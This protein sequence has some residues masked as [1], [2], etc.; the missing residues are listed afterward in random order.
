MTQVTTLTTRRHIALAAACLLAV[1]ACER[2]ERKVPAARET[3]DAASNRHLHTVTLPDL[4]RAEE[5]VRTQA[6]E[7]YNA[8]QEKIRTG[9]GDEDLARAY[10]SLGMFLHAAEYLD[11]ALP[12]YQNAEALAPEDVRWPYYLGHLYKSR[13]QTSDATAAFTRALTLQP[14]D[15]PTLIWLAR[16]RLDQGQPD[17]AAPLLETA[18]AHAPQSPAVMAGLGHVALAKQQYDTA[19]RMFEQ[20]LAVD[21]DALSLHAP[22]ANAYRAV[23]KIELA[24]AHMKQWRNRDLPVADPRRE[25]LDLQ[26]QSGLSYEL[27]GLKAMQ[28]QDWK[29]A[30]V[31][32]KEG[33]AVAPAGSVASRSLH[34]KLGTAYYMGGDARAAINEFRDVLRT[35]PR[36]Q[37]DES[38]AKASYS[39]GVIL[40]SGGRF[41]DGINRL[42]TA[43]RYQPDYGEAHMALADALRRV[44]R[45][46]ESTRHYTEVMRINPAAVEAPFGYAVA[47]VRLGRYAEARQALE[48]SLKRQQNHPMLTQALARVLA[49]AP[50]ARV[51]DGSRALAMAQDLAR[52]TPTTDV[53][54]TLAM[55]LAEAGDFTRAVEMQKEVMA[56]A[57]RA[58]FTASVNMMTRN[59]RLYEAH[60][61]CRTPWADDD[62]VNRPGPA[63]THE[64]AQ[65]ANA[66]AAP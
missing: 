27:R 8:L 24:E 7:Y 25:Q 55:A 56:A 32:F 6:G 60:Q 36:D 37:P 33:L 35:A 2:G 52:A 58:G 41:N 63:V 39:L 13:G 51:R 44:G 23:G 29:G 47:L 43:V 38:A 4:G 12:C 59:L 40:I 20:G 16:L 34:H 22:L 48:E 11:A 10:G 3:H 66:A 45:F 1:T 26:V 50:D 30:V 17:A 57:G 46:D 49:T 31:I 21:P 15:V 62:P 14:D 19:I 61:P 9:A 5:G 28:A 42:T 18:R 65:F 64:L 54:E 53:G